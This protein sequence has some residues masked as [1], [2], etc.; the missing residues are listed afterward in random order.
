MAVIG[1]TLHFSKTNLGRKIHKRHSLKITLLCCEA[2]PKSEFQFE[3]LTTPGNEGTVHHMTVYGCYDA[4]PN[5]RRIGE[6]WNCYNAGTNMPSSHC[7]SSIFGWAVGSSVS[8]HLF[9]Q[10]QLCA[11]PLSM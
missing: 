7:T 3:T 8:A 5:G 10:K 9:L 6:Q 1:M 2:V 11:R 4:P